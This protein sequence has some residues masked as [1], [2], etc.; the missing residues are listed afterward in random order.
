MDGIHDLGGKHGYG[1]VRG[2][3]EPSAVGDEQTLPLATHWEAAVFAMSRALGRAGVTRNVDHFRHAVER[4]DPVNY[5]DDSYYGRWLGGFETLLVEGGI[6]TQAEIGDKAAQLG[7]ETR[8]RVAARPGPVTG[9]P[10]RAER[11]SYGTARRE[12]VRPPLFEVGMWV[13]TASTGVSGHTRLP[14]YAR[15]AQGEVVACHGVWVYPDASAHG[16]VEDPQHLYTVR[17]PGEQLWGAEGEPNTHVSIDLFEPYL[18]ATEGK[19]T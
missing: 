1:P 8:A 11:E 9:L 19:D 2:T 5:L 14:A 17:F 3:N 18:A 16:P 7:G 15:G 13:R 6:V 12:L 10:Q 4:I